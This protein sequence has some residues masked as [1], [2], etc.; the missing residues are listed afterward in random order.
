MKKA[1]GKRQKLKNE[2]SSPQARLPLLPFASC[3]LPFAFMLRVGLTGSIA[4]GKSFVAGVLAGLCCHCFGADQG[5]RGVG[6][7]RARGRWG[8]GRALGAA[9]FCAG[10]APT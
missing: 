9:A 1:R 4:V 6:L 3:L 5:V 7:P 8:D 2:N 10:S